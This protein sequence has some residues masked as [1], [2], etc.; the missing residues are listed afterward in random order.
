MTFDNY[1]SFPYSIPHEKKVAADH[2]K[3]IAQITHR[4]DMILQLLQV[5]NEFLIILYKECDWNSFDTET[6][7]EVSVKDLIRSLTK[8]DETEG[9]SVKLPINKFSNIFDQF[10]E[11]QFY[12]TIK[13]KDER[14]F[15]YDGF[16][17][18]FKTM[19]PINGT[20]I[21]EL[22]RPAAGCLWTGMVQFDE[23]LGG[24]MFDSDLS[25]PYVE[26]IPDEKKVQIIARYRLRV[27]CNFNLQNYPMDY[28]ECTLTFK[29]SKLGTAIPVNYSYIVNQSRAEGQLLPCLAES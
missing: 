22:P 13:W 1:I 14:L 23:L 28:Q 11:L 2:R 26:F 16:S 4:K 19:E 29:P 21:M 6:D 10:M 9:V 15:S 20:T 7:T 24:E 3:V 25:H 8:L 18:K 12:T 27:L 17:E 5:N